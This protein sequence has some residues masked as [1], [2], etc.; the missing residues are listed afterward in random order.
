MRHL[1]RHACAFVL[2]ACAVQAAP[3]QESYPALPIQVIVPATAGGPVDTGIRMIEPQL[4]VLLGTPLVLVNHIAP[5]PDV[6]A[7]K[8]PSLLFLRIEELAELV[9]PLLSEIA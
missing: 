9:P 8:R 2:I 4:S 6:R 1:L 7:H 3:A 5:P